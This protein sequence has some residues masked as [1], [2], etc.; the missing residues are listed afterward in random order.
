MSKVFFGNTKIMFF[1]QFNFSTA[2][3]LSGQGPSRFFDIKTLASVE[4]A[5][6]Q[7]PETGFYKFIKFRYAPSA[8]YRD[9]YYASY[10]NIVDTIRLAYGLNYTDL[11]RMYNASLY[12]GGFILEQLQK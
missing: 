12:T 6:F 3:I 10:E 8:D 9:V 4:Y 1:K 11:D 2:E 7:D 5:F